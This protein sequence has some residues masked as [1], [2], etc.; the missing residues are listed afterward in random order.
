MTEALGRAARRTGTGEATVEDAAVA[1]GAALPAPLV[2]VAAAPMLPR[3]RRTTGAAVDDEPV[4]LLAATCGVVRSFGEGAAAAGG[5]GGGG[6]GLTTAAVVW[7]ETVEAR[8][9]A[10]ADEAAFAAAGVD[11]FLRL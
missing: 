5:G 8:D 10:A 1:A 4:L 6:S 11:E 2:E 3:W 7:D 9:F